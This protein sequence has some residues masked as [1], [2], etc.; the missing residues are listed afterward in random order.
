MYPKCFWEYL[1]MCVVKEE[2]AC[3]K[4]VFSMAVKVRYAQ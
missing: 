2:M 1:G 3:S 4:K